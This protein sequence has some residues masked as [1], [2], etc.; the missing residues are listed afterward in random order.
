MLMVC[1][2]I[3]RVI[4]I[5]NFKMK[6]ALDIFLDEGNLHTIFTFGYI[7]RPGLPTDE[8]HREASALVKNV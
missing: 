6:T 5:P 4:F 3:L 2:L 1:G 8:K 7:L